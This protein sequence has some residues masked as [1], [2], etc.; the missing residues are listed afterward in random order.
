M[1]ADTARIDKYLWCVRLY[2]TRTLATDAVKDGKVMVN[3]KAV[4]PSR[5]L[6]AGEVI[7]IRRNTAQFS[8]TVLDF[9]PSRV[10]AP[11]V[12]GFLT[13]ITPPEE[14]EKYRLYQESQREWRQIGSGKPSKKNRRDIGRFLDW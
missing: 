4:K 8:Y 5:E 13:D 2:K 10:G 12:A 11:L 9:P 7:T 14:V 6:K 1:S 3:G